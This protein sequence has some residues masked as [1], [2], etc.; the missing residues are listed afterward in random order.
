MAKKIDA[1]SRSIDPVDPTP[2]GERRPAGTGRAQRRGRQ[3]VPQHDDVP[4]YQ[5]LTGLSATLFRR[6]YD[7]MLPTLEQGRASAKGRSAR[8]I[9]RSWTPMTRLLM[10]LHFIRHNASMR[11]ISEMFGGSSSSVSRE[12]WDLVPRLYVRLLD[13]IRFPDEPPPAHFYDANAAIDCTSHLRYRVHP[14]SA[15]WYRGD[16]GEHFVTAQLVCGLDG[17]MF[18]VQLGQGHNNDNAKGMY[19]STDT[20]TRL[21]DA[22]IVVLADDGYTTSD[23]VVTAHSVPTEGHLRLRHAQLRSVVEHNFALVHMFKTAGGIFRASPELQEMVL[24]IV[25]ALV[26]LKC[27]EHPLRTNLQ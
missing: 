2:P 23:R 11:S 16:V 9:K 15:E 22:G 12:I 27:E 26:Y 5:E 21:A 4:D 13:V 17:Q 1:A 19:T 10:V 25:Y 6:I 7:L 18:D 8:Y 3:Y 20:E 14:W 24:M